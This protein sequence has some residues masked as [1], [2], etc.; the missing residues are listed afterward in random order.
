MFVKSLKELLFFICVYLYF[1]LFDYIDFNEELKKEIQYLKEA[2]GM[3]HSQQGS[4]VSTP[5]GATTGLAR[6]GIHASYLVME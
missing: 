1:G 3:N 2:T 6:K 5:S 4:T